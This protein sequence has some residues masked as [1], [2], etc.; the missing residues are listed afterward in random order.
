MNLRSVA[1]VLLVG[2]VVCNTRTALA[3]GTTPAWKPRQTIAANVSLGVHAGSDRILAFDHYGDPGV[4]YAL[5]SPDTWLMYARYVPGVGWQSTIADGGNRGTSPSLAFDRR[6]LPRIGYQGWTNDLAFIATFNGTGWSAQSAEPAT[7]I[8][9]SG[10]FSSIAFDSTGK[11][12]YAHYN[13]K[14]GFS[15]GGLRYIKDTDG[16]GLVTDET[17][18]AVTNTFQDQGWY[19]TLAFDPQ[20][21]P[22]IAHYNNDTADLE[23]AVLDTGLGW[24][25]TIVDSANFTGTYLSMAI[26]PDNGYPAISYYDASLSDLRYAAWNGT[27]WNRTTIDST[28]IVGLHTSLAF[29]PADGNPAIS[30][31]DQTNGNLKL[32]WFNGTSWQTQ[33][34]DTVGNVGVTTSLA[35]NPYGNGFPA[36]VYGD[37]LNNLYF[38]EDPPASVPEPQS[39]ILIALA[40]AVGS[41]R[42][43]RRYIA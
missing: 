19:A 15:P 32:A 33:N 18:V 34:V 21:R 2:F 20:D 40:A 31:Y 27:T 1:S 17:S 3:I 9:F 22:M 5:L 38:I 13:Y 23:F 39:L 8:G 16:D 11:M 24:V 41:M 7:G 29:D 6:E 14:G 26:D 12:A 43:Q 30:Y 10:D 4:A 42:H 25:N 28:G 36:I 37:N 35:F